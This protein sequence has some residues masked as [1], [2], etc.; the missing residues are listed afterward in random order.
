MLTRLEDA[1]GENG[2]GDDRI[3]V[4][5][6]LVL[7]YLNPLEDTTYDFED[8]NA[9]ENTY[10]RTVTTDFIIKDTDLTIFRSTEINLGTLTTVIDDFTPEDN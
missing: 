4:N 2:P 6:V 8:Y 5:G 9:F 3:A 7:L 1:N 10:T